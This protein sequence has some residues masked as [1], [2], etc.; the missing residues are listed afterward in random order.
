MQL[1]LDGKRVV[2]TG[3][4]KGIGLAITRAL[5]DEGA[6][7]IAGARS[8]T[9]DLR[10]LVDGGN[11]RHVAVDLAQPDGA[12]QLIAAAA[13]EGRIDVLVNNVGGV[14]VRTGG[15]HEISDDE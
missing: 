5:N 12:A 9:D 7:V 3:A 1:G 4:S 11:V 6:R 13:E 8:L 14:K 15:F 10:E 2:V